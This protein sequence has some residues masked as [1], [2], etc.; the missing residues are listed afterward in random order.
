MSASQFKTDIVL[1]ALYREA[2]TGFQGHAVAVAFYEHACERVTLE[3]M[4]PDGEL[5]EYTFD[6][7][8]LVAVSTGVQ[9][10]SAKT[11]GPNRPIPRRGLS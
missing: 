11:G 6:S 7:P 2:R 4:K 8:R 1:G 3:A 9:A 5:V 10:T